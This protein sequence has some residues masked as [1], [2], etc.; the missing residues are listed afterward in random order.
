MGIENAFEMIPEQ[1]LELPQEEDIP[2]DLIPNNIDREPEET[3]EEVTDRFAELTREAMLLNRNYFYLNGNY[4]M[5]AVLAGN[6]IGPPYD[7]VIN[8]NFL[9][10]P[11]LDENI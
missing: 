2:Q 6:L 3:P 5:P 11:S 7:E 10:T 9:S 1:E 4:I 8:G